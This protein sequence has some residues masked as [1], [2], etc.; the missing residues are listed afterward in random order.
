M[1]RN[2]RF[3]EK[4]KLAERRGK[5]PGKIKL[6]ATV[7]YA[8]SCRAPEHARWNL[9]LLLPNPQRGFQFPDVDARLFIRS[10]RLVLAR[11]SCEF[12]SSDVQ[13]GERT[14]DKINFP[15]ICRA[16]SCREIAC[17]I[18]WSRQVQ[19][20]SSSFSFSSLEI[21]V[22]SPDVTKMLLILSNVFLSS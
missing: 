8:A 11:A 5:E 6:R 19:R 13:L 3:R 14:S 7:I 15:D 2:A 12:E 9:F 22:D 17:P 4:R 16:W 10:S 1:L 21:S 18:R 20:R